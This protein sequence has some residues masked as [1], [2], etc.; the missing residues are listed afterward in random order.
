M[1]LGCIVSYVE[2][3]KIAKTPLRAKRCRLWMDTNYKPPKQK[4]AKREL[5]KNIRGVMSM[6]C[7]S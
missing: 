2:D 7:R 6:Y 3:F 5:G 4:L 1:P